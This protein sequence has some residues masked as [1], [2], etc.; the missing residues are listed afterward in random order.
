MSLT[1]VSTTTPDQVSL[2]EA[3]YR[4][5][6]LII[7]LDIGPSGRIAP[8]TTAWWDYWQA[9]RLLGR[10]NIMESTVDL[11]AAWEDYIKSGFAERLIRPYCFA[12][13]TL[14]DALLAADRAEQG[15]SVLLRDALRAAVGFES[16]G[17]SDRRHPGG[18]IA[19]VTT[20]LRN[21]MYLLTRWK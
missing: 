14:L 18:A 1:S 12:Y 16:A 10:A 11:C 19:A 6:E 17:V 13:F 20:T 15:R 8:R 9:I 3:A 5:P 21:P 7:S 2:L 4:R